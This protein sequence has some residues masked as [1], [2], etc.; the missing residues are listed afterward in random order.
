MKK[1]ICIIGVIGVSF[2]CVSE[3][4]Q[5]EPGAVPP[6]GMVL[7]PAGPF[8]MGSDIYQDDEKPSRT[9][10][11]KTFYID[12]N[13]VTYADY[14]K[15]PCRRPRFGKAAGKNW[16]GMKPNWPVVGV[17]WEDA[18]KYCRWKKKRL[19]TEAE[20]EKAARGGNN[21]NPYPWGSNIDCQHANYI[22][23]GLNHPV[24]VGSYP[25]G[26]SPYGVLDMAGNAQEWVADWYDQNYYKNAPNAD[27]PGPSAGARKVLR[28]GSY[29]YS[30]LSVRVSYRYADY[31]KNDDT[32]Y[33]FRCAASP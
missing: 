15:C 16:P 10:A 2:F 4:V 8:L 24:D 30:A 25:L 26:K 3:R 11:L 14:L 21:G 18:D 12:I 9:V 7:I 29:D 5:P 27:P 28:G 32:S 17:S 13:E 6:P 33:G 22:K 20:W 19:P 1:L 31:P 23:C